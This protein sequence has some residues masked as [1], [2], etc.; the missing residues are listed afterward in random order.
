MTDKTTLPE[1][2]KLP[3]FEGRVPD[4]AAVAFTGGAEG[5]PPHIDAYH[6][7]QAVAF[8][9]IGEVGDITHGE[10][11]G[12]KD[13]R[14]VRGHKVVVDRVI[15]LNA[16]EAKRVYNDAIER[17]TGENPEPSSLDEALRDLGEAI[18]PDGSMTVHSDDSDPVTVTGADL[19]RRGGGVAVGSDPDEWDVMR[20]NLR[21]EAGEEVEF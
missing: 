11:G 8:L 12:E 18:G 13:R 16:T 10:K 15:P 21:P 1:L 14:Y 5:T 19:L 3:T 20:D 2:P 6:H 9:V 7:G 4:S 17:L